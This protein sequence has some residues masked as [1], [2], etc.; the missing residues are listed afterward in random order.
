MAP[1]AWAY[2]LRNPFRN[3]FDRLTGDFYIADVGQGTKEEIDFE[4]V[5]RVGNENYGWPLREGKGANPAPGI[6]GPQPADGVDPI[7][8]YAHGTGPLQ[9]DAVIGGY[10]YR[11]SLLGRTAGTYIFGDNVSGRISACAHTSMRRLAT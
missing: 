6:G 8:D 1:E 2:G 3:S 4:P 5:N 9:G 11:G 7:Y 10:V